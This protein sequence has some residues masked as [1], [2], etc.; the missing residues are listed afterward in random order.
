M[1]DEWKSYRG[2]GREFKGGHGVVNH[3]L[4]EFVVGDASTNTVKSYF[5]L[6]KRGVQGTF[7]HISK[8][9]LGR[10][11]N[12]FSFRWNNRKVED[13][14]RAVQAIRGIEGKR[15]MYRDLVR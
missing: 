4:G 5:A 10:Y 6:L 15:V 13:G 14:E 9:H 12:E 2:L 1:T 7:H 3:G 8:K 11:C